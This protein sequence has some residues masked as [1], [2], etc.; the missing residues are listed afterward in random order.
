MTYYE[1][2]MGFTLIALEENDVNITDVEVLSLFVT[3]CQKSYTTNDS[4]Y[5][6]TFLLYIQVAVCRLYRLLSQECV[7]RV[8]ELK[9]GSITG[10]YSVTIGVDSSIS[11][12]I[13]NGSGF[14]KIE[15]KIKNGKIGAF[16]IL[17]SSFYRGKFKKGVTKPSRPPFQPKYNIIVI[18]TIGYT[19]KEFCG[20]E[21][22]FKEVIAERSYGLDGKKLKHQNIYIVDLKKNC[23]RPDN[24]NE[25]IEVKFVVIG[26]GQ[27]KLTTAVGNDLI[28]LVESG[29]TRKLGNLFEDKIRKVEFGGPNAPRGRSGLSD[30]DKIWL[31]VGV[32]LGVIFFLLVFYLCCCRQPEE[33]SDGE[34][35]PDYFAMDKMDNAE[36]G[37]TLLVNEGFDEEEGTHT[38]LSRRISTFKDDPENGNKPITQSNNDSLQTQSAQS[39]EDDGKLAPLG[40]GEDTDD[41]L[42]M[43]V[44]DVA[45]ET[46]GGN[47]EDPTPPETSPTIPPNPSHM[48]IKD[49]A[50]FIAESGDD[51]QKN[52]EYED[53][54]KSMTAPETYAINTQD[55]NRSDAIVPNP[56]TRVTTP[57]QNDY[58]NANFV[59]DHHGKD[60]FIV[61]QHP[62]SNTMRDFWSMVWDKNVSVIVMV[63]SD[64]K[65]LENYHNYWLDHKNSLTIYG[66]MQVKTN[67][68]ESMTGFKLTTFVLQNSQEVNKT[69]TVN[70]FRFANW[71]EKGLP[72][73]KEFAEFVR[74][75]ERVR[76]ENPGPPIVVHCSKGQ[77]Y[78]GVVLATDI[79]LRV[80]NE[81]DK[82][83][84]IN[85]FD[86]VEKMR[87]DRN[88]IICSKELYNFIYKVLSVLTSKIDSCDSKF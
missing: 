48:A 52:K 78:T 68:T 46:D 58:I 38:S 32:I 87:K 20:V 59:K 74:S 40:E 72:D 61:T 49:I 73:A 79:G 33:N 3:K 66:H 47:L 75:V 82:K 6:Q 56:E 31:A 37:D 21:E 80:Y 14:T 50:K 23:D 51:S 18:V 13:T 36:K 34:R 7:V 10:K 69:K 43:T 25:E 35:G 84:T 2:N 60:N 53:L 88:G 9:C 27:D 62:L 57:G 11:N 15:Q 28:D 85:V 1:Y 12:I 83:S 71:P 42:D 54:D 16:V 67:H 76:L 30:T 8:T 4:I 19:W 81:S 17:K 55:R 29:L 41:E 63:N 77:G 24:R 26:K 22:H 39:S 64:E 65:D 5:F 45:I 70:H 44:P 86:C